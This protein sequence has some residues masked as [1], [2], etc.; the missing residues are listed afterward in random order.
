MSSDPE[1]FLPY[2]EPGI[3]TILVQSSFLLILNVVNALFDKLVFCGLLGQVFI[4]TAWG[5]PGA[6]VSLSVG[7]L[8]S[9]HFFLWEYLELQLIEPSPPSM[10]AGLTPHKVARSRH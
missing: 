4:G 1:T 3:V 2:H 9:E 7:V 5:T 10:F 6:K 8:F